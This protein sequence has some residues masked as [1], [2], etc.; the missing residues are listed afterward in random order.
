MPNTT[1]IS[2]VAIGATNPKF[3]VIVLPCV[4]CILKRCSYLS[5]VFRKNRS[6]KKVEWKRALARIEAI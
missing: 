4:H 1:Q 6:V 3:D 2:D 5:F